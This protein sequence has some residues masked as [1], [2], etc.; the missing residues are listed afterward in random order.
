[1]VSCSTN[2][3]HTDQ[4]IRILLTERNVRN[5]VCDVTILFAREML[6]EGLPNL[7][8]SRGSDHSC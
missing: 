1:M 5:K 2:R 3:E 7:V 4:S 8:K 6:K